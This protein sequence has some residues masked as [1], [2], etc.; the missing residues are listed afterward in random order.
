MG[1]I[2]QFT[3]LC[4]I[5]PSLV[6]AQSNTDVVDAATSSPATKIETTIE[7][8]VKKK[9]RNLE[10]IQVTGSHIRR[11]DVEGPSPV[12]VIDREAIEASGFNDVGS[13]LRANTSSPFGGNGSTVSLRGLGSE[14]TLILIDGQRAPKNG[15]SY[16][17]RSATANFVPLAAVQR[18]EILIDGASATYGSEAL[19]GVVNII[20]RKDLDGVSFDTKY[21]IS[22]PIGGDRSR[23]SMAYASQTAN[24]SFLTSFQYTHNQGSRTSAFKYRDESTTLTGADNFMTASSKGPKAASSCATQDVDPETGS[25]VKNIGSEIMSLPGHEAGNVTSYTYDFSGDTQFYSTFIGR[26]TQDSSQSP[27]SS[28]STPGVRSGIT[29][30]G[31]DATKISQKGWAGKLSKSNYKSGENIRVFSRLDNNLVNKAESY[32]GGLI[33]GTKGYM[34]NSDWAWNVSMNN[35]MFVESERR[36][37]VGLFAPTQKALLDGDLVPFSSLEQSTDGLVADSL[38][39]STYMVNWADAVIS[40]GLGDFAGASWSSA[41]GV[42]GANFEYDDSRDGRVLSGDFMGLSGVEGGGKRQLYAA[43]MELAGYFGKTLETQLALRADQYSDFGSTVNPKFAFRYQPAKYITFRGSAG[44]G[45]NAPSLQDAYGPQLEGFYNSIIDTKSCNTTN[46]AQDC[47]PQNFSA[48]LGANRELKQETSIN[49]NIGMIVEPIKRLNFSI[50]YWAVKIDDVI[51]SG[52]AQKILELEAQGVDVSKYGA[53]VTRNSTDDSIDRITLLMSNAGVEEVNGIDV[54]VNYLM[55]TRAGDFKLG[56]EQTY[57]FNYY[58]GFYDELGREQ[59]LGQ[60][61]QPRWRNVTS[62]GYKLGRFGSSIIARSTAR[63]E[64]SARGNGNIESFTQYDLNLDYR[65][66]KNTRVQLGALNMFDQRPALDTTTTGRINTALYRPF[67]TT[68]LAYRQ[69]F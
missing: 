47:R 48:R 30:T 3:L 17:A 27:G 60:S 42:S 51:F 58:Q 5:W 32:M 54:G 67:R 50:D 19:G 26:Y 62:L 37:G 64:K 7:E 61:G 21:D 6:W 56:T 35:Q 40:G 4:L 18:V 25:C 52:D 33:V 43:Y 65:V 15:S 36:G 8:P 41:F 13:L 45:F 44:T 2:I 38:S 22:D 68:Y 29:F 63:H 12:I 31:A 57:L 46:T 1:R 9:T 53:Q 66:A 59:T 24:S 49:Y 10:T 11:T 14:R 69:T 34:G 23:T 39:R 55:K 16:G 20:T 28:F